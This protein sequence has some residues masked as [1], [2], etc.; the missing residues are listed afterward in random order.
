M[1]TQKVEREPTCQ[2]CKSHKN[3]PSR[4]KTNDVY[5]GRKQKPC[6]EFKRK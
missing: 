3:K 6:D 1:S 4:C 2:D 5:V